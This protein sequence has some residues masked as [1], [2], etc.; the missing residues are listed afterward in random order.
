MTLK[1]ILVHLDHGERSAVRL[2]LAV[3]LAE[4]HGARLVGLFAETA[5][6]HTV[7]VVPVWPSESYRAAAAAGKA[8]FEAATGGIADAEWRDANRGGA[9]EVIHAII[10]AAHHVD[11]VILGQ[12]AGANPAPVPV[13]AAEEVIMQAGRPVLVVP[14]IGAYDTIGARPLIAWNHS[15]EASRALND[16]LPLIADCKIATIAGFVNH[17]DEERSAARDCLTQLACHGVTGTVEVM[18]PDGAGVMDMLLNRATDIGADLLVMGA[19]SH[20]G[21]PYLHRGGGTRHIL[22]HM[23]VP[24]LMSH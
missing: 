19:H 16:C 8:A 23:T 11:L 20:I 13:G 2:K 14:F 5:R 12:D 10:E 22:A 9:Q 1:N 21:F 6:A 4:T 17:P 15:R 7:G 18:T 24:V 3:N